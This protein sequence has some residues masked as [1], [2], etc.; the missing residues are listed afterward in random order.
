MSVVQFIQHMRNIQSRHIFPESSQRNYLC[1][2]MYLY[3]WRNQF[4][5]SLCLWSDRII[6]AVLWVRS[7]ARAHR[8]YPHPS[9]VSYPGGTESPGD[10]QDCFKFLFTEVEPIVR[11]QFCTL[12][13]G[14]CS[15]L[16]GA[17]WN[18][19]IS[20]MMWQIWENR[21]QRCFL[22][23]CQWVRWNVWRPI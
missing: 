5:V 13:L 6:Q 20:R 1:Y 22:M 12:T 17:C 8:G 18:C 11:Q 16:Y 4:M 19:R 7:S 23:V 3:V 21:G 2:C 15:I 14:W 9:L 10:Q